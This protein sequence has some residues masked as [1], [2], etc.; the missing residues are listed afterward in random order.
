[1]EVCSNTGT[2]SPKDNRHASKES[3]YN[4]GSADE[5][6]DSNERLSAN[7]YNI[8][9]TS[10]LDG[11]E[12]TNPTDQELL[13]DGS[14]DEVPDNNERMSAKYYN[15]ERM[16]VLDGGQQTNSTDQELHVRPNAMSE[17]FFTQL[18]G[19]CNTR[20]VSLKDNLHVSR[21]SQSN[22]G[23]VDALTNT[24]ERMSAS[25]PTSSASPSNHDLYETPSENHYSH[26]E[27]GKN[28]SI[29]F[30]PDLIYYREAYYT[31]CLVNFRNNCI[32]V[33]GSAVCGDS[34][35]FS[36]Q[37]AIDDINQIQLEHCARVDSGQFKIRVIPRC[38]EQS[39]TDH[40]TSEIEEVQFFVHDPDLSEK[41]EAIRS[42]NEYEAVWNSISV[43]NG[44]CEGVKSDKFEASSK[45]YFPSCDESFEEVIYP[46]GDSDAVSISKRDF[47]LLQPDTF[48]NDTIIDFYIMYLKNK[49]Q[50]EK[51]H[52]Y[53][54][55][56]SFFFRKLADLD[57]DPSNAFDGKAAFLRVRK[58]TR[59]VNLF[60]KDFVFIPVNYNL[61]WSLIVICHPGE[62]ANL[63]ADN[64]RKL[65]RVPCILHMDSLRGSHTGLKDL[66]QSYL[67]EE[68][69]ERL[70][71]FCQDVS[72]KFLN[73]RFVSL[74]V[75]QQQNLCDCG[76][77]LL[78]YVECFLEEDPADINP[79]SITKSSHF[80]SRDWFHYD[81]PYCKRSHIQ[82]LIHDL[83]PTSPCENSP[84]GE[85]E[86]CV[87][88]NP[89][90]I[91]L[92]S[93]PFG[94][95]KSYQKDLRCHQTSQG[96]DI[97]GLSAS[98]SML[99]KQCESI[100][101]LVLG[102]S[103]YETEA[104]LQARLDMHFGFISVP[105]GE[106]KMP[107]IQEVEEGGGAF[108]YVP[109]SNGTGVAD[110]GR[111]VASEA[112]EFPYSSRDDDDDVTP[113]TSWKKNVSSIDDEK[114][115]LEATVD[116]KCEA[117]EKERTSDHPSSTLP[118]DTKCYFTDSVP[119]AACNNTVSD[120]AEPRCAT[121]DAPP[122]VQ[123]GA[124]N[125]L[126]QNSSELTRVSFVC[127][128]AEQPPA[129]RI[130]QM[131]PEEREVDLKA[132]SE[133]LHL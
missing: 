114:N 14:V 78:H 47:D 104:D 90:D 52:R 33:E 80:L 123:N 77:F 44:H 76:L 2:S 39:E 88:F 55:F 24:S 99:D 21:E 132:L 10:E 91:Q 79:F 122:H 107:S 127:D 70:K 112:F 93:H 4:D 18:D 61:H 41:C 23:L 30:H 31:D 36:T 43:V 128:D 120:I 97:N 5:V 105:F 32:E 121:A 66:F 49:I 111:A 71:E 6:P 12:Q 20:R 72:P 131:S 124:G 69:K 59:K 1:M 22:D 37:F 96:Y 110:P 101:P 83:L 89:N 118:R 13:I 26:W 28:M 82:R 102:D 113:A 100:S 35:T 125:S 75:P 108:V 7:Y 87:P 45:I 19:S 95:P 16:P 85:S 109:T 126:T 48:V 50:P 103:S 54:F 94:S 46:K 73:L 3:E 27:M 117:I 8:E 38:S 98:L 42:L 53:H 129:K 64:L 115:E 40:E 81:E 17:I 51:R 60:E 130:R 84:S 74:E 29:V 63:E 62:V 34:G 119:S 57:K 15:L 25:A 106:D 11:G 116:G 9:R 68:W 92:S 67:W 58:W 133:D 86:A 56:N 65:S